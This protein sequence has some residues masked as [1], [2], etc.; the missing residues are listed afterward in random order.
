MPKLVGNRAIANRMF[1]GNMGLAWIHD[2]MMASNQYGAGV[3]NAFFALFS[4]NVV[5]Q[6]VPASYFAP[7][8]QPGTF[9]ESAANLSTDRFPAQITLTDVLQAAGA[10][11]AGIAGSY[12][13]RHHEATFSGTAYPASAAA[14]DSRF[15]NLGMNNKPLVYRNAANWW[16]N[17]NVRMRPIFFVHPNGPTNIRMSTIANMDANSYNDFTGVVERFTGITTN[18]AQSRLSY[19]KDFDP[20]D[21]PLDVTFTANTQVAGRTGPGMFFRVLPGTAPAAGSKFVPLCNY[22]RI[23][24]A[25]GLHFLDWG[26]SGRQFAHYNTNA[27]MSQANITDM[28]DFCEIDTVMISLYYNEGATNKATYLT[29]LNTLLDRLIPSNSGIVRNFILHSSWKPGGNPTPGLTHEESREAMAQVAGERSGIT[30]FVDCTDDMPLPAVMGNENTSIVDNDVWNGNQVLLWSQNEPGGNLTHLSSLGTY[31]YAATL[32]GRL[33]WAAEGPQNASS[34]YERV[35]AA[36]APSVLAPTAT[37]HGWVQSY[38]A[39]GIAQA[40]DNP[41]EVE[42]WVNGN[43]QL[44]IFAESDF[45]G[46]GE[47]IYSYLLSDIPVVHGAQVQEIINVT[48]DGGNAAFRKMAG[49]YTAMVPVTG[50][51]G[52][53]TVGAM[54]NNVITAGTIAANAITSGSIAANAFTAA[55]FAADAIGGTTLSAAA[56]L[57]IANKVEAEIIDETDSEKVLQAITDKIASVNP[58]LAGLTIAAI[59][60]GVWA[61][62]GGR[63]ITGGTITTYTGNTPQTGDSYA[64][65]NNVVLGVLDSITLKATSIFTLIDD[66]GVELT[67]GAV[68]GVVDGVFAKTISNLQGV[69]YETAMA[70]VYAE[71]TG[72]VDVDPTNDADVYLLTF[73]YPDGSTAFTK[74]FNPVVGERA[75][76]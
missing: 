38:D 34:V 3:V 76:P 68:A 27:T 41:P 45:F 52:R 73:K 42:I 69:T 75:T 64:L 62:G 65:L 46:D 23:E 19:W 5:G 33:R 43:Y 25:M 57:A 51:T 72:D 2:S 55:K 49:S 47:Y 1:N 20:Q 35:Q 15:W 7:A 24:D 58:S 67:P 66:A 59:A 50:A 56:L 22:I 53:V 21:E 12:L 8:V 61:Y 39:T 26:D 10:S 60:G 71:A 4:G 14:Y 30:L 6:C 16:Y 63:I 28:L 31:T 9:T 29:R 48:L 74:L 37:R 13:L 11:P 44:S 54:D 36:A 40:P 18:N 17:Q 32:L 70:R